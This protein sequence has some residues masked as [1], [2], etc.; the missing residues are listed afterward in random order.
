MEFEEQ[1]RSLEER[2]G[3]SESE[4]ARELG[5]TVAQLRD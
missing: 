2:Y 1:L 5:R 4:R 3:I